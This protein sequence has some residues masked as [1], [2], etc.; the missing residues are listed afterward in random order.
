MNG[1]SIIIVV[2][3]V[4]V[5]EASTGSL[6]EAQCHGEVALSVITV[7]V[8]IYIMAVIVNI[9]VIIYITG[10]KK[11]PIRHT[12]NIIKTTTITTLIIIIIVTH[13]ILLFD[14]LLD[15]MFDNLL[16]LCSLL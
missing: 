12:N 15:F 9:A 10:I 8:V 13:K 11:R 1:I 5:V 6:V 3:I 14:P 7:V 4:I 2:V 16:T